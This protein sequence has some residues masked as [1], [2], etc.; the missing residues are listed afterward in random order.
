MLRL[1]ALLA[2][3][4]VLAG[5]HAIKTGYDRALAACDRQPVTCLAV[6]TV[7]MAAVFVATRKHSNA[8]PPTQTPGGP[9]CPIVACTE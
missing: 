2:G 9:E 3:V 8:P 7:S 6:L 4:I 5:C 1:V